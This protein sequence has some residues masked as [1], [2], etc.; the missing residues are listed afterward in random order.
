MHFSGFLALTLKHNQYII[1]GTKRS[2]K[3]EKQN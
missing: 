3:K 1:V 2:N